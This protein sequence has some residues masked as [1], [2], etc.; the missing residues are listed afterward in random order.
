MVKAR[1]SMEDIYKSV[2]KIDKRLLEVN[3]ER[4]PLIA[5]HHMLA[6]ARAASISVYI[7]LGTFL[8]QV[9]HFMIHLETRTARGL[10][11]SETDYII[12]GIF[13]ICS[14]PTM[15]RM[16]MENVLDEY[17]QWLKVII[18]RMHKC[19]ETSGFLFYYVVVSLVLP[20]AFTRSLRSNKK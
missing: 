14:F 15:P 7:N 6:A 1:T 5:E 11:V 12:D 2:E 19:A 20:E 17:H 10:N 13:E 9:E 3:A 18:T 16:R 4:L 8:R